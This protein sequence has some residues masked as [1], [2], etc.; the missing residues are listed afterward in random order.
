MDRGI[1]RVYKGKE[2]VKKMLKYDRKR[3]LTSFI[4]FIHLCYACKMSLLLCS[5]LLHNKRKLTQ[6]LASEWNKMICSKIR[7]ILNI[8]GT[9]Q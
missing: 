7:E 5:H 1:K 8:P 2:L 9:G 4:E 3:G 6:I